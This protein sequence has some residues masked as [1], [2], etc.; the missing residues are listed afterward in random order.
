MSKVDSGETVKAL[1][2]LVE[3]M[4]IQPKALATRTNGRAANV[5]GKLYLRAYNVND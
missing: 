3:L 1:F 2:G 5:N 4:K